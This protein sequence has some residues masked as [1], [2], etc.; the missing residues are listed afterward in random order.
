VMI[1][2]IVF[3]IFFFRIRAQFDSLEL[4]HLDRITESP[5]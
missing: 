5:E 3:G 4:H 2:F 1:T